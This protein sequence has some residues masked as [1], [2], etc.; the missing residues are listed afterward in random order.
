MNNGIEAS[1][2]IPRF[3]CPE[4]FLDEF[5]A[6]MCWKVIDSATAKIIDDNDPLAEADHQIDKMGPYKAGAAGN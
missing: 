1:R 6:P 4:I 5:Y 3:T 2:K